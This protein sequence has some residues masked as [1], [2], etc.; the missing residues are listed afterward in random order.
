MHTCI[1]SYILTCLDTSVHTYVYVYMY[2]YIYIYVGVWAFRHFVCVLRIVGFR[3]GG[4][5]VTGFA[6]GLRDTCFAVI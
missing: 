3:L 6:E 5:R 1:H 2:M 4:F